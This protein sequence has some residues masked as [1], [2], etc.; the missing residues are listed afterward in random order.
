MAK[1][2][3]VAAGTE[4]GKELF[5]FLAGITADQKISFFDNLTDGDKKKYKNSRYMI[6]RFLSMNI[7]YLPIV[8]AIQAYTQVPERNHYLFL[9]NLLPRGKQY[10][11]YVKGNKDDKYESWLIEL[12][13]KHFEISK[14]EATSYI[15]IY[16]KQNTAELRS[17]CELYGI[18]NKTLKKI[19]L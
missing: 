7:H 1:K 12:V 3:V 14:V 9:T 18:D 10:N 5:D 17:I 2:K 4:K 8:N 19:K 11:K 15:E 16:Y 13:A 6:H